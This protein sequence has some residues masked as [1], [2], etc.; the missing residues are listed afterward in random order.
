LDLNIWTCFLVVLKSQFDWLMKDRHTEFFIKR[1][2]SRRVRRPAFGEPIDDGMMRQPL[3]ALNDRLTLPVQYIGFAGLTHP[4]A[5]AGKPMSPQL[6]ADRTV[7]SPR[8]TRDLA[9]AK[10]GISLWYT[11]RYRHTERCR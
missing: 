5:A 9:V 10:V 2:A 4:T 7:M 11:N 6:S 3:I 8:F 1:K